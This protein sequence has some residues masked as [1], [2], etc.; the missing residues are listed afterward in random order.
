MLVKRVKRTLRRHVKSGGYVDLALTVS[1]ATQAGLWAIGVALWV[2]MYFVLQ[3]LGD[4]RLGPAIWLLKSSMVWMPALLC[5]W[6]LVHVD[7]TV[8]LEATRAK[9][10]AEAQRAAAEAAAAAAI[11]ADARASTP[12]RSVA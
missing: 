3:A 5:F 2:P 6:A 1:K 9:A 4:P 8:R 10:E 12:L 7:V 11:A